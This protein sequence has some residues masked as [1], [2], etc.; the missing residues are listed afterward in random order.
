[1]NSSSLNFRSFDAMDR[2]ALY[3]NSNARWRS[4]IIAISSVVMLTF[5]GQGARAS[6]ATWS[7]SPISSDWNDASN[8][9]PM[10]VPNDP[11]DTATFATSSNT[12][13]I[14]SDFT[15]LNSIAFSAG[16]SPF[17]ITANPLSFLLIS[18]AG[19]VNNSGALQNFVADVDTMNHASTI[20]FTNTATAGSSTTF[21]VNGATA[22]SAPGGAIEF[23]GSSSAGGAA[24]IVAGSA[25]G[26]GSGGRINFHENSSA[27]TGTFT[28]EGGA[29]GGPGSTYFYNTSSAGNG[30]FINNAGTISGASVGTTQFL[31]NSSAASATLISNGGAVN[32]AGGGITQFLNSSSA[33]NATVVANGGTNG[34]LVAS[35]LFVDSSKAGNALLIANG[36][37]I[38]FSNSSTGGTARL[39]MSDGYLRISSHD[40]P[41][42]ILGSIEGS[43]TIDLGT[44]NLTLGSNNLSTSYSGS[45]QDNS[46]GGS[47]TKNGSGTLRLSGSN[48]YFGGTIINSGRLLMNGLLGYGAVTVNSG[49]VLGGTGVVT[50]NFSPTSV[51]VR[52]GAAL[53]GGNATT[54]DSFLNLRAD[55]SFDAGSII[56]LTLGAFGAHSS[57][58]RS[59]GG[60][61]GFAANQAFTF[62]DLGAAPGFYDNIITGLSSDPGTES[63]WTITNAGFV[64]TFTYDGAGGI[65][66][67]LN[68]TSGPALKLTDAVSR[69]M[70]GSLGPFDV[71]LLVPGLPGIECRSGGAARSH[72]LVFTFSNTVVSGNATV[73]TGVGTV[74]SSP[75]FI[76]NTMTVNLTGVADVQKIAVTLD[77]VTDN[78]GQ[79]LPDT[80]INVI[81]LVG[82]VSKNK[83]VNGTDVSQTK[84]QSGMPVTGSNFRMDVTANGGITGTDVSLVK[85]RSGFGVP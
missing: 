35:T 47:L 8:W 55:L 4:K 82:D 27:G 14:L 76:E 15:E 45:I 77:T 43:G 78:L 16:G 34:G 21:R 1:M 48:T 67:N 30:I 62:L 54:A 64:G 44:R 37:Q 63:S 41:G 65:D 73:T 49:S 51:N 25:A 26:G 83:T 58:A 9:E 84:V 75:I 66:L 31:N 40:F 53:L 22:A 72:T 57:L 11:A 17:T 10:T 79:I 46:S 2:Q 6:S 36:G 38:F 29:G 3:A 56:E 13:A 71:P 68:A 5:T 52:T 20:Y 74:M 61:W 7:A 70:H 33:N 18:G 69:K 24:C 50:G 59:N 39:K 60:T 28:N 85:S 81:M 23:F 12:A 80:A 42:V 19:I 32:G